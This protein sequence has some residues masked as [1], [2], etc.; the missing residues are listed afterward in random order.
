MEEKYY[1]KEGY[2][3]T[4]VTALLI[5]AV[6]I[7]IHNQKTLL[8]Q[9]T[10]NVS[11][12]GGIGILLAIGMLWKWAYSDRILAC[13]SLLGLALSANSFF[14]GNGMIVAK[15]F[16]FLALSVSTYFLMVSPTVRNFI[17]GN[18]HLNNGG[19]KE[20]FYQQ[21]GF[22]IT[23]LTAILIVSVKLLTSFKY[24]LFVEEDGSFSM[25]GN[26]G[27]LLA[28]GLLLKWK[29]IRKILIVS[30]FFGL[31]I[32]IGYAFNPDSPYHLNYMLLGIVLIGIS[33]LLF[34]D[35]VKKYLYTNK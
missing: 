29:H 33:Y 27:I 23:L 1:Q 15:A 10:G 21:K 34:S 26:G 14:L 30:V 25:F 11:L 24:T 4:L 20:K 9:E 22:W 6:A 13:F 17:Y 31:C 2:W 28:A 16:L 3:Q 5:I 32:C 35:S 12:F 8:V 18:S 7:A 19:Q